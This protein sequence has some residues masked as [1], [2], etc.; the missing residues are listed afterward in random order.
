MGKLE[1]DETVVA[2]AVRESVSVRSTIPK[3]VAKKLGLD[4]GTHLKW[5]VDKIDGEWVAI[6]RKAR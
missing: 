5:D 4:P 3:H 2:L 6:I 1:S